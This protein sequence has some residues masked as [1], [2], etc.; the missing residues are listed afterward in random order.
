MTAEERKQL[1][2]IADLI[3]KEVD[4][5]VSLGQTPDPLVLI[6]TVRDLNRIVAQSYD[7]LHKRRKR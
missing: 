1:V 5:Q 3:K 6:G 4:K 7:A 2:E